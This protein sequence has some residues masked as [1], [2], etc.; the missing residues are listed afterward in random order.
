MTV[1]LFGFG[2]FLEFD[3]NPSDLVVKRLHGRT[4]AGHTVVGRTLPVDY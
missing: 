2:P 4:I 3:E 1:V